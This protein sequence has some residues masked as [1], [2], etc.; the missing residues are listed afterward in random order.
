MAAEGADV[1]ILIPG[2]GE[3]K[4]SVRGAE[5]RARLEEAIKDDTAETLELNDHMT[6]QRTAVAAVAAVTAEN[7]S[8]RAQLAARLS[9]HAEDKASAVAAARTATPGLGANVELR[10]ISDAVDALTKCCDDLEGNLRAMQRIV[11]GAGGGAGGGLSGEKT[12]E[13]GRRVE[14]MSV[15]TF[16][17]VSH[18]GDIRSGVARARRLTEPLL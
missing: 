5:A 18:S 8:L 12:A 13:L 14:G 16:A 2:T 7:N 6:R 11:R 3:T 1:K 9:L 10:E 15:A 17:A 4:L